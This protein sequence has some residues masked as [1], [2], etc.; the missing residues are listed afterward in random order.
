MNIPVGICFCLFLRCNRLSS[1][2]GHIFI[3]SRPNLT[4]FGMCSR[5]EESDIFDD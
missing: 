1:I 4:P 2:D 5:A 3:L